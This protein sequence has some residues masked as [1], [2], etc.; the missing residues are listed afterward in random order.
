MLYFLSSPYG[1]GQT[2]YISCCSLFFLPAALRA[3]QAC[4]QLIYSEAD[5]EVIRHAGAIRCTDGVKFG[6]ASVPN[7][8]PPV[9]RQGCRTPKLKF[10][11]RFDRSVEYK[12][13]AGAYPLCDFH[14]ICRVYIPLLHALGFEIWLDLIK[15]LWSYG[16]FKLRGSGSP[17]FSAPPSG[18]T[19]RQTP[20]RFC[21]ERTCSRSS[22]TVPSLV[23]LGFHP[24]PG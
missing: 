24:P 12:R 21:G 18:K 11:L 6:T 5:F 2:I 20:K 10:L 9:Q 19:M 16:G 1:I 4:R 8:T 14:K 3:A 13:P 17:K 15:G 23:G 22:I 7:F